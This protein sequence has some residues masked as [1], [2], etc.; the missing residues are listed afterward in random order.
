MEKSHEVAQGAPAGD[1]REAFEAWFFEANDISLDE[2]PRWNSRDD[3]DQY[4]SGVVHEAW[5]TWQARAAL[6]TLPAAGEPVAWIT[7]P[8]RGSS[9]GKAVM[10]QA[11]HTPNLE[12]WEKPF[13]VYAAPPAAAPVAAGEPVAEFFVEFA[14]LRRAMSIYGLSA[15]ESNHELGS[16]MER[17]AIRVIEAV[18][19]LPFPYPPAAAHGDDAV[20]WVECSERLPESGSP[21]LA[22]YT[23]RAG[24]G[25]RIRANYVA[26]KS[27]EVDCADPDTQCV[28]YDEEADC[29][30]LQAGWYELIDNWE[31]Y[32]SIAVIEGEV[33]HWVALPAQ[34]AMRAQAG[35]HD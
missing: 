11:D 19:K 30:Y 20:C 33:S 13:P 6:A 26:P 7:R 28:E 35:D 9:K 21:V 25:R 3:L 4:R 16:R 23:N 22:F 14:T 1:E 32:S 24:K 10:C 2:H 18:A 34:P 15:P 17:Y 29:F 12:L 5:L 27:H 8:L 31:E